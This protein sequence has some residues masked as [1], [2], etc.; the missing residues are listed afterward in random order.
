MKVQIGSYAKSSQESERV[1]L[2]AKMR[3]LILF[4]VNLVLQTETFSP[5][6]MANVA[7]FCSAKNQTYVSYFKKDEFFGFKV[8]KM[9]MKC[10]VTLRRTENFENVLPQDFVM[11][12]YDR[13][14]VSQENW[15]IF[16]TRI[17]K[18]SLIVVKNSDLS[19]LKRGLIEL[20]INFHSYCVIYHSENDFIWKEIISL[21]NLNS[22]ILDDLDTKFIDLQGIYLPTI[23]KNFS[24]YIN[25]YECN[26][27][28][29]VNCSSDGFIHDFMNAASEVMNFTWSIDIEDSWG[30]FPISGKS[31]GQ[32]FTNK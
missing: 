11:I 6:L 4:F 2:L 27:S 5:K 32:L 26:N 24:P 31:V 22:V 30:M 29:K 9:F 15:G 21:K 19:H 18:K 17:V 10:N 28:E 16:S 25:V 14:M 23:S 1:S 12:F 13:G 8:H 7:E 3:F 20:N